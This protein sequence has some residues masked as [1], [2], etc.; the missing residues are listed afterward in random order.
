MSRQVLE[1]KS[2]GETLRYEID[3]LSQLASG[4]TI[5]SVTTTMSVFAGTDSTPSDMLVDVPW[6]SGTTVYQRITAGTAGVIY[7]LT[8]TV[9]TSLSQVLI[10]YGYL[11]VLTP[12][13]SDVSLE[14]CPRIGNATSADGSA[15]TM[16]FAD[17]PVTAYSD[18]LQVFAIFDNN[19]TADAPTVNMDLLGAKTIKRSESLSIRAYEIK[20]DD[21]I[22]LV[23]DQDADC[24]IAMNT[25]PAEWFWIAQQD[26]DLVFTADTDVVVL[27][28][29]QGCT[30]L[31][32]RAGVKNVSTAGVVTFD[33]NDSATTMLSTKLTIDA[34]EATS[35]T[36]AAAAV[37]SVRDHTDGWTLKMDIDTAG[38]ANSGWFI[39][40]LLRRN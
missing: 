19:V 13:G 5:T 30:V 12:T 16:T 11:A 36:A 40:L 20:T 39:G 9:N 35:L 38:T 31:A 6:Y 17:R 18:G 28:G 37:I 15:F 34:N 2:V 21:V 22:H 32:V 27:A 4:E 25:I 23:F 29:M 1:A 33:L 7:L 24:F 14:C 10:I 8:A 26:Q 3:F